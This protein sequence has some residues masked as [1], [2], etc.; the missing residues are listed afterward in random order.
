MNKKDKESLLKDFK[1][2]K[3]N[4]ITQN[5]SW[6]FF[7]LITQSHLDLITIDMNNDLQISFNKIKY[8]DFDKF[9]VINH[10]L[11]IKKTSDESIQYDFD[12]NELNL[13]NII[14]LS[15][16]LSN[17]FSFG[18]NTTKIKKSSSVKEI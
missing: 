11:L 12:R 10:Q 9:H 14:D 5:S 1:D 15:L 16:Y 17:A 7:G 3:Y 2:K 6:V 8:E 4:L 18:E 13:K